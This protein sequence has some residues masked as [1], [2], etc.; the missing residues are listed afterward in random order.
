MG[1]II[2]TL[3]KKAWEVIKRRFS[4]LLRFIKNILQWFSRR[5]GCPGTS[6][7]QSQ[8]ESQSC[9]SPSP[10]MNSVSNQMPQ[11]ERSDV[12]QG[13]PQRQP[14]SSFNMNQK[15]QIE[16]MTCSSPSF[17]MK[18]KTQNESQNR[19]SSSFDMNQE[20]QNKSQ[21]RS[22]PSFDMKQ[23]TQNESQKCSGPSFNMNQEP[24]NEYQRHSNP[25][26]GM[27]KVAKNKR[28]T[29]SQKSQSEHQRRSSFSSYSCPQK[30]CTRTFESF[31]NM[32]K[33]YNSRHNGR[34]KRR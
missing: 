27:N 2:C 3:L 20:P 29:M 12:R 9:P 34:S 5:P 25:L 6:S 19:S 17:D 32:N 24:Q 7:Q 4:K 28:S 8:D 15:L 26:S 22:N 1:N 23:E 14:G 18:Q 30:G 31:D 16:T 10:G 13:P 11:N 33:H 21:K